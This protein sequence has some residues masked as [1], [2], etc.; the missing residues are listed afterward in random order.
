MKPTADVSIVVPNYNNGKFLDDFMQSIINS[1]W[2]PAELIILD[3]GSTDESMQ[4]LRKY[5]LLTYLRLYSFPE[6]KG[7]TTALNQGIALATARYIMRADPDDI[8]L[9]DRI[10]R[11][12]RFMEEHPEVDLA[13]ANVLY[14]KEDISKVINKSNFPISHQQIADVYRKGEHGVQHPTIIAKAEIYKKY[15]YQPVFP[16]EDYEI[17]SRMILDGCVFANMREPVNLMRVHSGSSTNNLVYRTI[18]NT[19]DFRDRIF[20]TRTPKWYIWTYYHHIKLYRRYQM[21]N[22]PFTRFFSLVLS[23][24][25]KP[26]KLFNRFRFHQYAVKSGEN[27]FKK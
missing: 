10:E 20:G 23:A 14:F 5:N 12:F 26:A 19:F 21:S 9:P 1:A 7:L 24:L 18:A 16:G 6:N 15:R 2:Q 13:G 4:V 17:F 11:Q 27:Q 3:D 8:L 25:L 22:N